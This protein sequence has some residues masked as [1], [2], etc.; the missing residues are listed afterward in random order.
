[1]VPLGCCGSWLLAL[2]YLPTIF[3]SALS[4]SLIQYSKPLS[5]IGLVIVLSFAGISIFKLRS[6][7]KQQRQQQLQQQQHKGVGEQNI[8]KKTKKESPALG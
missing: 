2:S 7:L 3:G 8:D 6:E 5:Y 1:L 4:V